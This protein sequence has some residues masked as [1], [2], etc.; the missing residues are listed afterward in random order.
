MFVEISTQDKIVCC[1]LS[2]G[3]KADEQIRES[4]KAK[5]VEWK[6]NGYAFYTFLSGTEDLVECKKK[7]L[8]HNLHAIA[9]EESKNKSRCIVGSIEDFQSKFAMRNGKFE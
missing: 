5:Q 1:W 6:K 3:E 4:I 9:L 8:I 7:L 2:K